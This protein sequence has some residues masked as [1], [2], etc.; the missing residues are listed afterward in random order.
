MSSLRV[1]YNPACSKCRELRALLEQR[2]VAFETV[3]YLETPP[4]VEELLDVA[5]KLGGSPLQLVRVKDEAFASS[6]LSANSSAREVA[7][8]LAKSPRLLER[9]IVVDGERALVA[10]PA[11][12]VLA[13]RASE[14]EESA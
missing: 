8:A 4:S 10:R 9:P 1:Y 3:A 2:G 5:R 7:E 14:G 13:L 11:E 6:G 12:T